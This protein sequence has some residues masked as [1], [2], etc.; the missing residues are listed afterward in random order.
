MDLRI[1]PA[2]D[3]VARIGTV[4]EVTDTHLTFLAKKP[5]SQRRVRMILP[6]RDIAWF[7][8]GASKNDKH[9]DVLYARPSAYRQEP[10]MQYKNVDHE[11]DDN[12]RHV[13]T[14]G[15]IVVT[16]VSPE[17]VRMS[18]EED[19]AT[20]AEKKKQPKAARAA[21][22]TTASRRSTGTKKTPPK[23]RRRRQGDDFE[24]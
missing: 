6:I 7:A 19:V 9:P 21:R 16:V 11:T 8:Q 22:K 13:F 20:E 14:S 23:R 1:F 24:E 4:E 2:S 5:R 18:V 3:V 10:E 15:N 17:L 12:G